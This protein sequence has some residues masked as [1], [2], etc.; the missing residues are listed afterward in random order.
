[1]FGD[2]VISDA[3]RDRLDHIAMKFEIKGESYRAVLARQ[4]GKRAT[5]EERA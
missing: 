4:L 1:M 3:I 5:V 2:P